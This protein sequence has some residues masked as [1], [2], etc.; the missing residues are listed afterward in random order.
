MGKHWEQGAFCTGPV[1]EWVWSPALPGAQKATGTDPLGLPSYTSPRGQADSGL[2][3]GST[4]NKIKSVTLKLQL[5]FGIQTKN[6]S[7]TIHMS[8]RVWSS[9]QFLHVHVHLHVFKHR[10][11]AL[12]NKFFPG[13]STESSNHFKWTLHCTRTCLQPS[14]TGIIHSGS[15]ACVLS[16]IRTDLNCILA[17]LGSPVPT[18]VQQITSAC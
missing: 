4:K 5:N 11:H 8:K 15:V 12:S 17:N 3:P 10:G 6:I 7:N 16:S 14:T 2:L 1:D 13:H 18:Q 9:I